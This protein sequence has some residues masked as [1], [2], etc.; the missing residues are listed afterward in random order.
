MNLQDASS[1]AR[2]MVK[3]RRIIILT[4]QV[5]DTFFFCPYGFANGKLEFSSE[6]G[7]V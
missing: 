1:C 5:P 3:G 4:L 2:D 7:S 6:P